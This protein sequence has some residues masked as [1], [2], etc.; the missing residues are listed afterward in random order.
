[1]RK[2]DLWRYAD[3]DALS[4]AAL[5]EIAADL[6]VVNCRLVNVATHQIYPAEVY[7]KNGVIVY[8]ESMESEFH[9]SK[10]NAAVVYD[11]R[12]GYLLPG[13]LDS[14]LHVESSMLTPYNFGCG[15]A[16]HG[17]TGVFTDC[18]EIVNVAGREA[19]AYMLEDGKSSPIRQFM[20]IPSCVPSV[21][22][23]ENAGATIVPEDIREMSKLDA[24]LVVGLAE[25]MNYPQV[26]RGEKLMT[27]ILKAARE[28]ELYLQSHYYRLFGR[29][30]AAYLIHGLGGNHELRTAEEVSETLRQGGWVDL[31][32]GSSISVGFGE[33]LEPIKQSPHPAALRVTVCTDDRHA[34]DI[35]EGHINLVV[36][37]MIAEGIEPTVAIA[38]AT[39]NIAQ[40]YDISNIGEVAVGKLADMIVVPEIEKMRPT[41]VFVGGKLI[42]ENQKLL[43][44]GSPAENKVTYSVKLDAIKR[45]DLLV[46]V[47]KKG[48]SE[49]NVNVIDFAEKVTTLTQASLP[50]DENGNL[51]VTRDD[52]AFITVFNRYGRG[53][54]AFAIAQNFGLKQGAVATTVSHDSHNLVVIWK[55]IDDA[56]RAVNA[57][58]EAGG[59]EAT[60][61][62]GSLSLIEL[63]IGGLMSELP[64]EQVAAKLESYQE[65]FYKAFGG[66][67]V[68]L[69]RPATTSLI[70]S[71]GYKVSDVGIVDVL[72]QKLIPLFP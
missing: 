64:A 11:A 70:V 28:S 6:A 25:V 10:A 26:V 46:S 38:C 24:E 40:E 4:R 39:K 12:G 32:G 1:M 3:M 62:G 9:I 71:P 56:V 65:H 7:I 29:D 49:V 68:S 16:V 22:G 2:L 72:A 44:K 36:A 67:K 37:K 33:L 31:R 35:L 60:C 53:N 15:V 63:P 50:V 5:G 20:L 58:I 55:N 43:T 19:F 48:L 66:A 47:P 59:G 57:L 13:L 17:T 51:L 21:P 61:I 34:K 69:L 52:L 18:H 41:A 23:L 27:D 30:L 42:A 45:S 8:V 14:H 54:R